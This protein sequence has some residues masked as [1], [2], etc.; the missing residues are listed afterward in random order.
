M[1]VA[2][3]RQKSP[4]RSEKQDRRPK[5]KVAP[6]TGRGQ[7]LHDAIAQTTR[8]YL[9][10][11]D[12]DDRLAPTALEETVAVLDTHPDVGMV[13]T[14]YLVIDETDTVLGL[15]QRC[16]IPY[17]PARLLVDFMTFH[18]R[19]MRREV[20]E[21]VGGVDPEFK[22]AQDYDLCLRLSEVTQIAHLKKPLYFY[23]LHQDNISHRHKLE[24][25][26]FTEMAIASALQRRGLSDQ[27]ELEVEVQA[28]YRLRRKQ[29]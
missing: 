24:Q 6:H 23:R 7:A 5:V 21:Q 15:G 18:F 9:G 2:I 17:S 28:Q 13:Y 11:V 25:I 10:L 16:G 12:S 26:H 29:P 20:Y 8:Q 4:A 22:V 19:L 3:A 27:F 1:E 14:D